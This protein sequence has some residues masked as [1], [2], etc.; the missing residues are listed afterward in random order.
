VAEWWNLGLEVDGDDAPALSDLLEALGAV[1]VCLQAADQHII[2]L[3]GDEPAGERH[4]PRTRVT[5]LVPG[6]TDPQ[7]LFDALREQAPQWAGNPAT[8]ERFADQDWIAA[9]RQRFEPLRF[10]RLGVRAS[11]SPPFA[12]DVVDIV[13]D[14][15]MA[16][17]TGAH[18]TTS[19]CLAALAAMPDVAGARVIDYGCGS[20]ILAIA[21]ARLGAAA[22]LAVDI[23]PQALYATIENAR[24]NGVEDRITVARP[25]ALPA[26]SADGLLANILA[27]PLIELASRFATLLLPGGRLAVSGIL[28]D[29]AAAVIAALED[30]GLALTGQDERTGW[31]RLDAVR[32]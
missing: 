32:R 23:D 5:A 24:I 25:E 4:W 26:F 9:F 2:A 17:G 21:A 11:W 30:A 27:R 13:I 15:G 20:G 1:A 6:D 14:P 8:R 12:E 28:A 29:Q 16:F 19:L 3:S 31:V 10:G 22:V 18:A 7:Q